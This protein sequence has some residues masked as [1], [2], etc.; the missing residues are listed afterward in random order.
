MAFTGRIFLK[1]QSRKALH[2]TS[3]G[4]CTQRLH[5][6]R[7]I[8]RVTSNFTGKFANARNRWWKNRRWRVRAFVIHWHLTAWG[9]GKSITNFNKHNI[10]YVDVSIPSTEGYLFNIFQSLS[11]EGSQRNL[12]CLK[13]PCFRGRV[14]RSS[15]YSIHR[16][17][18]EICLRSYWG[19]FGV[20]EKT[21]FFCWR[22]KIWN[23]CLRNFFDVKFGCVLD[24]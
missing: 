1:P 19:H 18:M 17:P 12:S 10:L 14:H 6:S 13:A 20:R 15:S 3:S 22:G 9:T 21:C 4:W 2:A 16:Y 23:E 24:W 5:E 11:I 8:S 7:R